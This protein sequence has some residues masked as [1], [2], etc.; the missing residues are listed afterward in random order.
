MSSH[1]NAAQKSF[2]QAAAGVTVGLAKGFITNKRI[3]K[4]PAYRKGFKN[5]RVQLVRDVVR[6][7]AGLTPYEKR[8]LDVL[9]IGS[10]NADKKIYKMAKKRLGTHRRAQVKR[11]DIKEVYAKQR[12]RMAAA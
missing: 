8:L 12:A 11:N 4:R 2:K 6:E 10:G 1:R 9:K 7:V 5:Q 3:S